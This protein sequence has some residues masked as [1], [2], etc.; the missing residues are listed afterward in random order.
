[1]WPLNVIVR[2]KL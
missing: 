1:M 2:R